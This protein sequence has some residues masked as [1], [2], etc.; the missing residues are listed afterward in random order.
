M[1]RI[2][3]F[4]F[5]FRTVLIQQISSSCHLYGIASSPRWTAARWRSQQTYPM[6]LA[7]RPERHQKSRQSKS[8]L[9]KRLNDHY[10]MKG[11]IGIRFL[12]G[13]NKRH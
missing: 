1:L 5:S 4:D 10:A 7:M 11:M 2:N 3:S 8:L 12:S 6:H 13:T 9:Y